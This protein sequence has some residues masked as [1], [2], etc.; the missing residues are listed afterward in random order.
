MPRFLSQTLLDEVF[1]AAVNGGIVAQRTTLF[2]ELSPFYTSSIALVG[3]PLAQLRVDLASL[4][5]TRLRDGSIPFRTWL[6]AAL[7]LTSHL[8]E[9][10]T[11]ERAIVEL[12]RALGLPPGPVA[13]G[14][15]G[16]PAGGTGLLPKVPVLAGNLEKIIHQKTP[17][18]DV[19]V[20]HARLARTL[21]TVARVEMSA[22]G[23]WQPRGTAFLVGPDLVMTNHHVVSSLVGRADVRDGLRFRFDFQRA[24]D[25]VKLPPGTHASPIAGADWHVLS[26]PHSEVDL[27]Q[28]VAGLAPSAEELDFALIRLAEPIGDRPIEGAGAP[29]QKRGWLTPSADSSLAVLA[30]GESVFIL[31]HPEAAP[32]Q[33]AFGYLLKVGP[34]RVRYSADTEAGSS[35]SP[36]L[37]A[38]LRLVALHHSGDPSYGSLKRA[39]YNQ[40][41]PVHAIAAM[42]AAHG[43]T[44]SSPP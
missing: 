21:P 6:R 26:A 40:G 12:D 31:Q 36:C 18:Q 7:S 29:G 35:G 27:Q 42:C 9:G 2:A 30:E 24:T 43:L 44:F 14:T 11:F 1:D 3:A 22:N 32:L 38:A 25:G 10:P 4:N 16:A 33:I 34:R 20:W 8:P 41:I 39:E 37:D 28:D 5:S 23:I 17:F 13:A 19:A 15:S